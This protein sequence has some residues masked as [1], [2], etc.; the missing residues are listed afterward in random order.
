MEKLTTRTGYEG[1]AATEFAKLSVGDKR[2]AGRIVK[3]ADQMVRQPNAS[4][5]QACGDWA[6]AKAAYRLFDNK[7]IEAEEILRPHRER[8]KERMGEHKRVLVIQDTTTLD[9][10]AHRQ[11]EGLGPIN[12]SE[13]VL[14]GVFLH[15]AMAATEQGVPLGIMSHQ[16]WAREGVK[17][18]RE[19]RRMKPEEKESH[20]WVEGLNETIE[21]RPDDVEIV[22]VSDRE[23]DAY[24]YLLSL[25]R[26]KSSFVVRANQDRGLCDD[27]KRLWER[28]EAE[29]VKGSFIVD[30]TAQA[31]R[32]A[33]QVELTVRYSEVRQRP[34][35]RAKEHRPDDWLPIKVQVILAR[36]E[37]PPEGMEPLEWMLLTN[38]PIESFKQ[39]MELL[40][41]YRLRW[42]IELYHKVLKSGLKIE[43]CRLGTRERL[44]RYLAL[45][46]VIA[47]R[48]LWINYINRHQPNDPCT[49]ILSESEWQALYCTVHKTTNLPD[50]IPS[51]R[52]V[53]RWIG[54]LGGF[55]G[56]KGDGEPGVTVLWRGWQRLTDIVATWR[57]L[58]A[59]LRYG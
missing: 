2:L 3:V 21:N 46:A 4:L 52:Q 28:V 44:E 30:I 45:C 55:L 14:R 5:N 33:R 25:M 23:S 16:V 1:W 51:V 11:T 29:A 6:D 39:A 13:D 49:A 34:P 24:E 58:K 12:R 32:P 17:E 26:G 15:T 40:C 31:K 19:Y 41:W 48:L 10:T 42:L 8:V 36:E 18:Y 7:R 37:N 43:E 47:W 9:Y 38:L 22:M 56:R 27:P 20:K 54:K 35:Y 59:G 53:V 50:Q 57:L